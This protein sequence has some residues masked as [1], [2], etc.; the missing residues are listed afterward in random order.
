[1][2]N[3]SIWAVNILPQTEEKVPRAT[4]LFGPLRVC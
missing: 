2:D 1:V 4:S 3:F